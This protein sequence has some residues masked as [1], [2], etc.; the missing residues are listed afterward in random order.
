MKKPPRKGEVRVL[1]E[2]D[3]VVALDKPA[4]LSSVPIHKN[5]STPSA[6]SVLA[7]SLAEERRKPFVVHRIDRFT[8]G[9]LLFA[10]TERDREALIQ[11]FLEHTPVREYLAVVRGKLASPKE[12]LV[13]YFRREGMFQKL[14]PS[15]DPT[16]TRAELRYTLEKPLQDASLVRVELVTG[17]QNQIRVQ[18]SAIG[19]PVVGDR[20]YHPAE[21]SETHIDRVALHAARLRFIHPRTSKPV[22]VEC[23]PP[24]DF[25][26]L[27]QALSTKR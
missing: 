18:F 5:T 6:L 21:A 4:G 12:T 20:K 15:N 9:V 22:T 1:Y 13:H 3:A 16:A 25:R 2:D 10:K 26:N 24:A 17:L 11:Q 19:N 27:V 14:R 7:A 8:S 23:P